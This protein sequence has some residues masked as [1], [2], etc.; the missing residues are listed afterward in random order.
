MSAMKC[1]GDCVNSCIVASGD[2]AEV[3]SVHQIH[4]Q[5]YPSEVNKYK[6]SP[7]RQKKLERGESG[8]ESYSDL[9]GQIYRKK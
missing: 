3:N 4:E 8:R 7:R 2:N 9:Y 6:I 1:Y 5:R